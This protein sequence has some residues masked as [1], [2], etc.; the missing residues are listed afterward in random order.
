MQPHS[1]RDKAY[2][3]LVGDL[4]LSRREEIAAALPDPQLVESV[5]IN[6]VRATSVDSVIIGL[7]VQFRRAFVKFGGRPQEL[8]ITLPKHGAV[9]RTFELA[10]LTRLFAIAY[11]EP[12]PPLEEHITAKRRSSKLN[13]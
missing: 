6:L 8:V 10:G 2:V 13:A 5:V 11:A 7:L 9:P 12:S 3:A 1:T 4:D